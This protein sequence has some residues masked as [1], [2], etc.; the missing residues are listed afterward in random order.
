M[1]F[2][3]NKGGLRSAETGTDWREKSF[4]RTDQ[5]PTTLEKNGLNYLNIKRKNEKSIVTGFFDH[6]EGI[7]LPSS[8]QVIPNDQMSTL[9]SY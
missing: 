3:L 4:K 8:I 9:P 6:L 2:M 7:Y 1:A 5:V